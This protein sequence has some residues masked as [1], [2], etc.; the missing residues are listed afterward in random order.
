VGRGR[1]KV[2]VTR[3]RREGWMRVSQ[4]VWNVRRVKNYRGTVRWVAMEME[5]RM[6]EITSPSPV[7]WDRRTTTDE[8]SSRALQLVAALFAAVGY[9]TSTDDTTPSDALA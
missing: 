7:I 9:L 2:K 5:S 8:R 1:M 3:M 6:V 4:E